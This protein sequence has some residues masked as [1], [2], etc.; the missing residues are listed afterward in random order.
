M[1]LLMLF[2]ITNS[3]LLIY[4]QDRELIAIPM[5]TDRPDQTECPFIVPKKHFQMEIGFVF[6]HDKIRIDD[7][8]ESQILYP[9]SLLKYGLSENCELRLVVENTKINF[10]E[11][12]K[13]STQT[14]INPIQ[15]GFKVR[16]LKEKKILPESSFIFHLGVPDLASP[17]FKTTYLI[18]KFRFT[19]QHNLTKIWYV[20]YNLGI[21]WNGENAQNTKIYTLTTGATF[22]QS[23]GAYIELYGFL[24]DDNK[25]DHR[26]NSGFTYYLKP[27]FMVD[28]SVGVGISKISP[29]M[30]AGIGCS[31][32]LPN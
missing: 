28:I 22:G 25:S 17:N 9:S 4:A 13:N 10:K 2:F 19:F 21:E 20:A 5:L 32:R 15:F 3:Y 23:L 6:Q 16:I 24:P 18:P 27:N 26:F 12:G 8:E 31:F 11:I 14:G 30:Y 29:N 7:L 1:K